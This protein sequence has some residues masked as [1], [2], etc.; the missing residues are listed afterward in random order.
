MAYRRN[1]VLL[2]ARLVI[3]LGVMM[4]IPLATVLSDPGQ[5]V[6]TYLIIGLVMVGLITE[7][8]L[9]LNRTNRELT[10]FLEN[11]RNRDF[12]IR[13]NEEDARGGRK[14]LYRT[15]NEVLQAY[16]DI[17][18]EKEIQFRFLDQIVEMIEVGIIVLDRENRIVLMNTAAGNLAGIPKP[19]TWGLVQEKNPGF[20]SAV[21]DLNGSGRRLYESGTAAG[22][23]RLV[24]QAS[25]TTMLDDPYLL[26]TFQDV[27]SV[28]DEKETGAWIRLMRTLN[29]E[30]RNSVTPIASL[31]DTILMIL[32]H[33]DGRPKT[34]DEI[35]PAG[36]ADVVTS[37][38]TLQQRSS[39]LHK[40]IGEFSKLTRIPSPEPGD[41]R[42]L[43]LLGE[44]ASLF[45]RDL[46][47]QNIGLKLDNTIPDLHIKADRE[48]VQQVLINLVK[49]S[50]EALSGCPDPE[51]ILGCSEKDGTIT[52]S[53]K[54]NGV[55]IDPKLLDDVFVPF[56]STK[57]EGSGIGLSLTRQ[58]MRLHG[59]DVRIVS[60]KGKGTIVYL[61][62]RY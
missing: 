55:G 11:I 50:M 12:S 47:K 7:L 26:I 1:T 28:V 52:L 19:E 62:F 34:P 30:I 54:D 18:I 15:F 10:G 42:V 44:T 43:S 48:L 40:F 58:I 59:G 21:D 8:V 36:L 14:K 60:T 20:A 24:I 53:V 13:F 9:F 51:I 41:L 57:K 4:C 37:A 25:R 61:D 33:G 3:I 49:N 29:H 6:F 39:S 45:E 56:Y 35:D 31:A 27:R 17:R 38:E 32:K 16:R 2:I 22:S 5:L 46:A 23:I